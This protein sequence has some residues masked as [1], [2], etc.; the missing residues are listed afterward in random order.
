M[1]ARA[2]W[3]LAGCAPGDGDATG[4]GVCPCALFDLP[5]APVTDEA[6]F[7]ALVG[8]AQDLGFPALIGV[9]VGVGAVDDLQYLRAWTEL[10]TVALDDGRARRYT[11]QYDPIVLSDPDPM[12]PAALAALLVHELGHVEDYVGMDSAELVSFAVWY[13]GQDPSSSDELAAYERGTDEKSLARGCAD[14]L[15][16]AREWIYARAEGDVLVDK[17]RNYDTPEDIAA[18]TAANGACDP[19]LAVEAP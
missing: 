15:A 11:V 12:P 16:V 5:D 13:A 14:G 10:D 3:L 6:G 7:A 17:L 1:L 8:Q 2:L 18:W 9:D 19:A 4:D